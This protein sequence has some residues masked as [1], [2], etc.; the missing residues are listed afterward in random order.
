MVEVTVVLASCNGE[1]YI[2]SQLDSL[3][4][5]SF[6]S[7]K[8][9]IGDDLSQDGTLSILKKYSKKHKNIEFIKNEK[10]LGVVLNFENLINLATTEYI[11]LCDQDDIWYPDK[12]LEAITQLKKLDNSAI[13]L[14]FHS[15]LEVVDENQK[16]LYK[17]FFSMRGYSFNKEKSLDIMLG[18]SGVMGNTIVLNQALK[19]KILPFPKS[20]EVHD[21]WIALVNELFGKRVTFSKPLLKYRIHNDNTSNSVKHL[22]KNMVKQLKKDILL[23][24]YGIKR[25]IVLKELL[26]RFELN[27]QEVFL[28]QEFIAYLSFKKS[29]LEIIFFL[30][31]YDFFRKGF[32]YK[33]IQIYKVIMYKK[34]L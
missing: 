20:L 22:N 34:H 29:K 33:L 7:F 21:Y 2:A 8:I 32:K 16:K 15:D 18:R 6:K 25:E 4:N 5:Q 27:T 12:L 30:F 17:S 10:R 3:L 9:L 1:K 31:K 11:A 24:Y 14:L 13:P 28:I 19:S 26:R 23:P